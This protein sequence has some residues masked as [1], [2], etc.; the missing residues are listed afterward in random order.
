MSCWLLKQICVCVCFCYCSVK[1]MCKKSYLCVW[2]RARR[3]MSQDDFTYVLSPRVSRVF[4]S[5]AN[6]NR[7]WAL[8]GVNTHQQQ[9]MNDSEPTR[10]QNIHESPQKRTALLFCVHISACAQTFILCSPFLPLLSTSLTK[11]FHACLYGS[12][13]VI[14]PSQEDRSIQHLVIPPCPLLQVCTDHKR[15]HS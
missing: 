7:L 1:C 6:K 2:Q 3:H 9:P 11:A 10:T 15:P 13:T 5:R 14:Q 8:T 12:V 4:T